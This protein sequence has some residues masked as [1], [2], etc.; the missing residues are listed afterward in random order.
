MGPSSCAA[1]YQPWRNP[2]PCLT[3]LVNSCPLSLFLPKP[4]SLTLPSHFLSPTLLWVTKISYGLANLHGYQPVSMATPHPTFTQQT[5]SIHIGRGEAVH[6]WVT[7][8]TVTLKEVVF[9]QLCSARVLTN[10]YF[11]K[12]NVCTGWP[13]WGRLLKYMYTVM[14]SQFPYPASVGFCVWVS[15]PANGG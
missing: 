12:E 4:L 1:E 15:V 3:L 5:G 8:S 9:L 14:G 13:K 2:V 10:I 7:L 6:R 11:R